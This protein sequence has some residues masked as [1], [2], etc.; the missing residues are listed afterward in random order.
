M[1]LANFPNFARSVRT[2]PRSSSSPKSRLKRAIHTTCDEAECSLSFA[3]WPGFRSSTRFRWLPMTA[4]Y[5]KAS[6]KRSGVGQPLL[7]ES[8]S[9]AGRDRLAAAGPSGGIRQLVQRKR[10]F[11][12]WAKMRISDSNFKALSEYS[13]LERAGV[14]G[15]VV[16][17]HAKV[18]GGKA[19]SSRRRLR[20]PKGG[21]GDQDCGAGLR[22]GLLGPLRAHSGL[23]AR[24][25]GNAA[26]AGGLG[27]RS[28]SRRQGFR[29]RLTGGGTRR[30]RRGGRG[31]SVIEQENS[32]GQ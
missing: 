27:F 15:T 24:H 10:R 31:T 4:F 21:L 30:E 11:R 29:C 13:D 5:G 18:P 23:G 6:A 2:P 20:D 1:R 14:E 16:R 8:G 17:A 22:A 9:P 26:A 3:S 19:G 25:G 28:P 12:R 32:A 7:P